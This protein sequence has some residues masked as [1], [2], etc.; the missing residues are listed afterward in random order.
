MLPVELLSSSS[1][2]A[3]VISERVSFADTS[4]GRWYMQLRGRQGFGRRGSLSF[5]DEDEGE[6]SEGGTARRWRA[7]PG[8]RPH[9]VVPVVAPRRPPGIREVIS[10]R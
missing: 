7:M 10:A 2:S 1:A 6:S 8:L 5:V 3:V 9:P 4:W